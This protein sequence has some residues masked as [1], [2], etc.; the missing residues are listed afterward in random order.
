MKV[1]G[2]EREFDFSRRSGNGNDLV[3]SNLASHW[4]PHGSETLI[5]GTLQGRKQ[6]N[7]KGASKVC[8][9]RMWALAL[10]VAVAAGAP[11]LESVLKKEK[12]EDVKGARVLEGRRKVKQDVRA[13]LGGWVRNEGGEEFGVEGVDG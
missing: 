6:F 7:V 4:T 9:K 1:L 10:Q 12:Y 3:P 8:R 5:G 11:A 2:T 13:V